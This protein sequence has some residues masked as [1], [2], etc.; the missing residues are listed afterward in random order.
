MLL[1]WIETKRSSSSIVII[2]L[3]IFHYAVFLLTLFL[4]RV[5]DECLCVGILAFALFVFEK[6]L[7][8]SN[9]YQFVLLIPVQLDGGGVA[10]ASLEVR[11]FT[12]V[13]ELLMKKG[14]L[15]AQ[16]MVH[17]LTHLTIIPLHKISI[18][19]DIIMTFQQ[20]LQ[21]VIRVSIVLSQS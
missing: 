4:H 14:S 11:A 13:G 2:R 6:C 9:L 19:I 12:L 5:I 18:L 8:V 10:W 3:L 15:L 1:D 20:L 21:G 17:N 7:D 16:L